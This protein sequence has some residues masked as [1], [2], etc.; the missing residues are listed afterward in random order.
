MKIVE[1]FGFLNREMRLNE[2]DSKEFAF[3]KLLLK[4]YTYVSAF[5]DILTNIAFFLKVCTSPFQFGN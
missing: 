4:N 1:F 3:K 5:L 2:E